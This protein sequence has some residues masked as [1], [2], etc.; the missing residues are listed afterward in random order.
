MFG[1]LCERAADPGVGVLCG[2]VLFDGAVVVVVL[3]LVEVVP[4]VA[5]LAIAAPPPT[6]APVTASV[7]TSLRMFRLTSFRLLMRRRSPGAV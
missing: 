2:A 4:E 3:P 7:I 6:S 1:Q 5:A